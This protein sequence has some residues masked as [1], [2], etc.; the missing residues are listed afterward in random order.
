[1]S[2]TNS[3]TSVSES[4]PLWKIEFNKRIQLFAKDVG[5]LESDVLIALAKIGVDG[6]TE[7][8][9]KLLDNEQWLT[10]QDLFECFCDSGMLPKSVLRMG[11]AELRGKTPGVTY[12]ATETSDVAAVI[13]DVISSNRPKEDWSDRELLEHYDRDATEI[14]EILSKRT[15]SRPCLIFNDDNTLNIV[16]S[17]KLVRI[18]KRQSTL[19]VIVIGDKAFKVYEA[20]KFPNDTIDASPF[21]PQIPLVD[22][23]C[24]QSDTNWT[25]VHK[26]LRILAHIQARYIEKTTNMRDLK[27]IYDVAKSSMYIFMTDKSYISMREKFPKAALKYDEMEKLN[28]LPTLQIVGDTVKGC[29]TGFV[30]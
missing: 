9:L 4:T 26:V 24:P 7:R 11:I 3:T 10:M 13:R 20:D 12:A 5:L 29:D 16:E 28:K 1:M 19:D 6:Q 8:S 18:A 21:F 2:D 23:Y 14:I 25:G 30:G 27:E 15:R 17:E 22:G